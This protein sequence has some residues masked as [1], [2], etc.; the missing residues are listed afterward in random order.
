MFNRHFRNT[1]GQ[2][3]RWGQY[4]PTDRRIS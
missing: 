1:P 2:G 3:T 4:F